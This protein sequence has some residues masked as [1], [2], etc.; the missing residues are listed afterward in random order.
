MTG[1]LLGIAYIT[2]DNRRYVRIHR[3]TGGFAP[4]E[5]RLPPVIIG[6]VF[7]IVGLAWFAATAS[8]DVLFIVPILAGIPFGLGFMMIFLA[9]TNYLYA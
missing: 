8:P 1:V 5:T 9:C 4:P 6:G 3:E 7:A 2:Y